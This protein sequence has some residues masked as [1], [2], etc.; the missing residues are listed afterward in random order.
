MLKSKMEDI[1][2]IAFDL[3]GTLLDTAKDFFQAVNILRSN[4]KLGPCKYED[5]RSRVSEG[6]LSLVKL[7]LDLKESEK[8][9]IEINRKQ[10]L[11]IY[12]ECCLDLT[13]PFEG[14][15]SLLDK[16]NNSNLNWG[17]VTNKPLAFAEK[18][19]DHFFLDYDPKCLICPE[20]TGNRKPSPKGLIKAIDQLNSNP[21]NTVYV[22]DHLIDIQA[23]KRAKT[24]TIAASYGYI[25][26]GHNCLEW[27]ADF[28]AKNPLEIVEFIPSLSK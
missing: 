24:Y 18:I 21:K 3:D 17:I 26:K 28:I 10:L 23:G 19:V 8:E 7:A 2:F 1:D 6:A 20:H 25:P 12:K 22:G 16:I 5:V 14:I 11:K 15:Y 27:E 4:N 13:T 9:A